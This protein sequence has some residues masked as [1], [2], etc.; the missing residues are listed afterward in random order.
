MDPAHVLPK[1][2]SL[3]MKITFSIAITA[4]ISVAHVKAVQFVMYVK[5]M[6]S[7]SMENVHAFM[8]IFMIKSVENARNVLKDVL[9]AIKKVVNLVNLLL[10]YQ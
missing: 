1:L 2:S 4:P 3:Q 9:S 10:F 8:D 7:L 5:R 6:P